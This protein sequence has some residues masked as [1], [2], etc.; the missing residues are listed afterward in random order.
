MG[1]AQIPLIL[2]GLVGLGALIMLVRPHTNGT[3]PEKTKPRGTST[4]V[5]HSTDTAVAVSVLTVA[6][7]N[8]DERVEVTGSL[9]AVTEVSVGA[10]IAGRIVWVIG[11]EGTPVHRG[12][13]VVRLDDTDAQTQLRVATAA[14]SAAQARYEQA[15]AA[16]TQQNTATDS[17][18]LTAKAALAAAQARLKQ[19]QTSAD[20][21]EATTN[22]QIKSAE[23]NLDAAQSRLT[24]LKNG[25]RTQ[26]RAIA[27]NAVELAKVTYESS[28]DDYD[29]YNKLYGQGAISRSVLDK[30]ESTM[31]IAKAQ[32]D[33]AKQQLSLV[34]DGARH[35]D[36]DTAEAT[37][38]QAQEG[39]TLAKAGLK[40]IDVA[41]A[42][43]EIAVTGVSQAEAG[44]EAA[45]S[46]RQTNIMRDKDVL[47][48]RIAIQ[49]AIDAKHLS[50]QNTGYTQVLSPVDGVVTQR[51]AATGQ[52]LGTNEPVL[53]IS[54]NQALYLEARVSELEA[55][56]LVLGQRA[57][58]AVDALQGNRAD[59]YNS[60][61]GS[62]ITGMVDRVVPVVD[63]HS[64]EFVVRVVVPRTKFL[65]PGMFARGSIL[66]A[67]HANVLTVPKDALV[68]RGD[69]Q[70]LFVANNGV[71]HQREVTLGASNET[72]VEVRS[73]LQP[74]EQVVM[75]GQQSLQD[76]DKVKISTTNTADST[77]AGQ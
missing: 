38:R 37:V 22:A 25:A 65:Y 50:K 6:P 45:K 32:Y 3:Q 34:Q 48:A 53:K 77:A 49:Q 8:L 13:V 10:R 35:E 43:V 19:S 29:R 1:K 11:D 61:L 24:A 71:V 62:T 51:V 26:E 44:L 63:A 39:V 23:A 75:V 33:S 15:V 16:A 67:Q 47:A 69:H 70:V 21:T 4:T 30:Y 56:R 72:R 66:V 17:N 59:V 73:G 7:T 20:A 57:L 40:Q 60:S 2:F 52:S 14:V 12:Q 31:K 58:V 42:N 27:E 5:A 54:T 68:E 46:A 55:P 64:R 28:K 74:G 41:H 9:Q 18:I 36:L 76:G